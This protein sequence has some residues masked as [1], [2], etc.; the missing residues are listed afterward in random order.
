[1]GQVDQKQKFLRNRKK[2]LDK[3]KDRS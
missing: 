2:A 3:T 1:M